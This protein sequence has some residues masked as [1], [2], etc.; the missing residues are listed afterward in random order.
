MFGA[1]INDT[2]VRFYVDDVDNTI[3]V[4][5]APPLCVADA[6]FTA[7]GGWGRSAYMPWQPLY[8]ILNVAV[9]KGEPT[10]WWLAHNATTLV[11]WVRWWELVPA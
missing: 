5:S 6:T 9:N 4:I 8:G 10:S 11:D 3:F 2:A 1:E 7:Q